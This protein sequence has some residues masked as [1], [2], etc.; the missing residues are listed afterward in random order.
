[1]TSANGCTSRAVTLCQAYEHSRHDDSSLFEASLDAREPPEACGTAL[2][3]LWWARRDAWDAAHGLV[4]DASGADAAWVHAWLHRA[5]GDD[6]NAGYWYR[7]AG[8]S[9]ARGSLDEEWLGIVKA[10]LGDCRT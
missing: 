8:R 1:M 10:L 4:Q 3:A 2:A 5:K 9:A 7:R 6:G